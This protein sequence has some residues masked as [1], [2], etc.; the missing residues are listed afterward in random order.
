MRDHGLCQECLREGMI[1]VADTVHHLVP[2]RQDWDRRLDLNNL[3]SVC[4]SC[5]N[6]IEKTRR[7]PGGYE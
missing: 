1:R 4:N 3:K 2:L 5:H 6:T 7:H